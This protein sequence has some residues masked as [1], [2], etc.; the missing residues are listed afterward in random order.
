M[1]DLNLRHPDALTAALEVSLRAW[2]VRRGGKEEDVEEMVRGAGNI[3]KVIASD[4]AERVK[5][6]QIK[7]GVL[8]DFSSW[9]LAMQICDLL[10][11]EG[12]DDSLYY[13]A[14]ASDDPLRVMADQIAAETF[15]AWPKG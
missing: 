9:M 4:L 1:P 15:A 6:K 14:R 5:P 10:L 3:A 8:L 7:K 2:A 11:D 13:A 12:S